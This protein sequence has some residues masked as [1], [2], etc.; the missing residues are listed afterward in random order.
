MATKSSQLELYESETAS[1]LLTETVTG[2]HRFKVV[3]YSL[4]KG[5]GVG[6]CLASATFQVGGY[7]WGHTE[8]S[9]D[10]LAFYLNLQSDQGKK[11]KARYNFVMLDQNGTPSTLS[12]TSTTIR[13]FRSG[14]NNSWGFKL[15]NIEPIVVS[16]SN[17]DLQLVH[18]LESG[19]GTDVTFE[20]NN[21]LFKAHKCVLAARFSARVSRG[22]SINVSTFTCNSQPIR[23]REV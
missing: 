20:V 12:L 16:P 4:H 21:N 19:K 22:P 6:N 3:G 8:L 15:T 23:S 5:I 14:D 9:K 1:T 2:S 10:Y 11:P 17:L 13:T 7:D 18:L